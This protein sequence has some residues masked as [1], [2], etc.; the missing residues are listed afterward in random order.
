MSL[1][2][3]KDAIGEVTDLL[4]TRITARAAVNVDV[5][6]PEAAA[7]N[8]GPKLNLFLFQLEFDPHLK[9]HSLDEGQVPPLWMV[10]RYLLTAFDESKDSDSAAAHRLL[11]QGLAALHEL[12]FLDPSVAALSSNPEPLKISFDAADA[13]LLSKIMQGS[14]EKYRISAAFQVRPVMIMPDSTPEYALPVLTVGPPAQPGVFVMPSMG[15]RLQSLSPERFEAGAMLSLRGDDVNSTID[16]VWVGPAS[17]PV[18]AA[19]EGE[20]RAVVPLDTSLSPGNYPVSVSRPLPNGRPLASNAVMGTLAPTI[21]GATVGP[22]TPNAGNLYGDVTFIG[23]RLG[24]PDDAIVVAFYRDGAVALM[25]EATGTAAQSSLVAHVA[26]EQALPPGDY[27][28]IL[29]VNGAQ[30]TVAPEVHWA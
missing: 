23:R 9:N 14:D 27:R 5:G 13:E 1:A 26:L 20:V 11:G 22:L 25:L 8:S 10:L 30:A 6:R 12:N 24:G 17:F 2:A 18:V 7:A 16:Q 4:R 19:R 21:I 29:R 28:L 15:P 3:S